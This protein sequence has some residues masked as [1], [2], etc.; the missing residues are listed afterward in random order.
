M[1]RAYLYFRLFSVLSCMFKI[2]DKKNN[3]R[4]RDYVH[5]PSVLPG[6]RAQ[7]DSAVYG[8]QR[9]AQGSESTLRGV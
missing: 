2:F 9:S 3:L 6:P 8:R 1:V 7:G 4:V 5:K